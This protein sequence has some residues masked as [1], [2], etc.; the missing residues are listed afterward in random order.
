[1]VEDSLED[2]MLVERELKRAGYNP[3]CHRVQTAETLSQALERGP[4]DIV[5]ADYSLPGF[6]GTAALELVRLQDPDLPFIIVSASIGEETAVEA[7]RAGAHDYIMKDRLARLAPAIERELREANVRNER[8]LAEQ[9]LRENEA[10]YRAISELTSDFIY[11]FSVGPDG[12]PHYRWIT[13]SFSRLTGYTVEDLRQAGGLEILIH[14]EDWPAM[15]KHITTLV[16]GAADVNEFR[17]IAQSGEVRWMRNYAQAEFDAGQNRTTGII[18]AAQDITERKQRERE[19]EAIVAVAGAL[20]APSTRASIMDTTL[21]QLVKLLEV[22]GG[23]VVMVDPVGGELVFE[24]FSGVGAD[25][26]RGLRL[27][28]GAGITGQVVA[29][30]QPYLNNNFRKDPNIARPDL[31]PR[32]GVQAAACV[33]LIARDETIGALWIIRATFISPAEVRLLAAIGDIAASALHRATLYEHTQR[34]V[35]HLAA[36]HD[37][38]KVITYSLDL[39][40]TLDFILAE[41]ATQLG[42][43]AVNLLRLNQSIKMLEHVTDIGFRTRGIARSRLRLGEGYAGRA[44]LDRR[45]VSVPDLNK[46]GGAFP[47]HSLL[48]GEDFVTYFGVPLIT[49][50]QVKGVL[51]VFHRSPFNPDTEWLD[52]LESLSTQAAI[53]MDN[54]EL[55]TDLRR[56]NDDLT[57]A[58]DATIEGWSK[59]LELRDQETEGHTQRAAELTLRLAQAIGIRD[60]ALVQIRRGVLLH[61]IGKMGVPD[62]ILLKPSPLTDEE[63]LVMRRHP[64]YAHEM[65]APIAYLRGALDI[66]YYHHEHWDGNGY[67]HGLKGQQIPL[68]ARIFAVVDTWDALR[69]DRPYRKSWPEDRVRDYIRQESGKHFDPEVVNVFLQLVA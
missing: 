45:R 14:P 55:L 6:S 49:K 7:M 38:H 26:A 44:A 16:S 50:G 65:L 2:A 53:A 63:W 5:L 21:D 17:I 24:A 54:D 39:H 69:N 42:V 15:Q 30:G 43:D 47:L 4:W 3:D 12:K 48:V 27:S 46:T 35:R 68:G 58:Y 60:D 40:S 19:M 36:L 33:P 61:D 10:R 20:R 57:L 18:G 22:D 23:A 37:I 52:F 64:V 11:S 41:A 13:D 34:R 66:P 28:S 51:E 62:S 56:Y 59:A 32:E 9:A 31:V 8:R 1:M 29:G 67:P 25:E